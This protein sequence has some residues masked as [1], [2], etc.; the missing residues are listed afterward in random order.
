MAKRKHLFLISGI[1]IAVIVLILVI[2]PL[3]VNANTFRP[4]IEQELSGMLKRKVAI[5]H[6]S[7][8]VLSGSLVANRISIG[9]DPAY[10]NQPFLTAK[11]LSVGVNLMPLIFSKKLEVRSLTIANPH[12]QLL[13][14]SQG[15]WN[16]DTL[17]GSAAPA[18]PA[19]KPAPPSSPSAN[20][21]PIQSFSVGKLAIN[22]A[23]IAFGRAGQPTRLAYE[24]ANLT[25]SNISATQ[26][27]PLSFDARTPGGGH[28]NLHAHVGPLAEVGASRLPFQGQLQATNVSAQDVQS[29][30]AVL[31]YALPTGSSLQGG[32]IQANL[33][34][35]G[36]FQRLVTSGPVKLSNVRLAG[37]SFLSQMA[38]AL[39]TARA[40]T[41]NDTLIKVASSDLRYAPQGLQAQ[42][43]N[44]VIPVLGT[45][46]GSGTVGANNQLNFRMIAKLAGSSPLAQLVKLPLFGPKSGGLPFLVQGTTAHPRIV[47]NIR[48]VAGIVQKFVPQGKQGQQQG[49]VIGGFLNKL[50]GSKKKKKP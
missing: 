43:L 32:T 20:S 35:H 36:P 15:N 40:A 29:L 18:A 3:F 48:G 9:D 21:S 26:A 24:N 23:T 5:G 33:D 28:L 16:F 17:G 12:I 10:S 46:T 27:F 2:T 37:Y 7:V 4:E 19:P 14:D 22:N 25:A 13:R 49:G 31:G 44:I 1:V 42:N 8:S 47:P 39:G 38:K 11:S 6:L 41:G 30:L 50:L 34:L 45:L